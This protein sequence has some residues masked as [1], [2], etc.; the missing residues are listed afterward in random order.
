MYEPEELT[1][2]EPADTIDF[3]HWA[4]ITVEDTRGA[5]DLKYRA[6]TVDT[7][8]GGIGNTMEEAALDL[9]RSIRQVANDMDKAV[10][11]HYNVIDKLLPCPFCKGEPYQD[12]FY[13]DAWDAENETEV[14]SRTWIIGC[15]KCNFKFEDEDL[16]KIIEIWNTRM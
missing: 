2:N 12:D 9:V 15:K 3:G 5:S 10:R 1:M 13:D 11:K 8:G 7:I 14:T 16:F 6:N 4:Y